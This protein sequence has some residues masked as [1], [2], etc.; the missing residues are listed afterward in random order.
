[1]TA[2]N[3][4]RLAGRIVPGLP[5]SVAERL[6]AS[7]R[8]GPRVAALVQRVTTAAEPAI[9]A[10]PPGD[11]ALARGDATAL[12]RATVLAGAVWQAGRIRSLLRAAEV[13]ALEEALGAE[14]RQVA[15]AHGAL[16][17]AAPGDAPLAEAVR[18]DGAVLLLAWREA[19]PEAVV[20]ALRL[21]WPLEE[22]ALPEAG[23]PR[24]GAGPAIVSRIAA[25]AVERRA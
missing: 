2:L 4:G 9:A 7:P 3:A 20:E 15:L 21:T 12:D 22:P 18:V 6:L 11:A 1:M 17:A 24:L 23:D 19:L 13:A 25:Q 5:A 14:A 16:A 10:L 8:L